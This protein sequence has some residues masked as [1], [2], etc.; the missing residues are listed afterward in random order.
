MI[1]IDDKVSI[2]RYPLFKKVWIDK[3]QN[4]EK[5]VLLTVWMNYVNYYILWIRTKLLRFK[6]IC[7]LF[8][9]DWFW[10]QSTSTLLHLTSFFKSV[11]ILMISRL[12]ALALSEVQ[13][14]KLLE[15][16]YPS[17][18]KKNKHKWRQKILGFTYYSQT[19]TFWIANNQSLGNHSNVLTQWFKKDGQTQNFGVNML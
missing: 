18:A 6:A 10:S 19:Q 7:S 15:K 12:S 13:N 9:R 16:Q 11:S 14:K 5:A 2:R 17:A 3:Q 8:I 4:L 1:K